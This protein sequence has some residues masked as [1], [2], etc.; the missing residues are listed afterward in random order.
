MD[1]GLEV[2]LAAGTGAL[3][4]K[5]AENAISTYWPKKKEKVE[6]EKI[7]IQAAAIHDKNIREKGDFLEGQLTNLEERYKEMQ[8]ENIELRTMLRKATILLEEAEKKNIEALNAITFLKIE[9][10]AYKK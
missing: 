4:L 7:S 9:L 8:A 10:A 3:L 6:S 1:N 5:V 2:T